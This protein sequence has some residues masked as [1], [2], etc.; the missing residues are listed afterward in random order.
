MRT[1]AAFALATL[2]AG[3]ADPAPRYLPLAQSIHAADP[4]GCAEALV[5]NSDLSAGRL[6]RTAGDIAA[7]KEEEAFHRCY[8]QTKDLLAP[9]TEVARMREIGISRLGADIAVQ[10]RAYRNC[11]TAAG[12]PP[13]P[14]RQPS[15]LA[16]DARLSA[17]EEAARAQRRG[18]DTAIINGHLC[19]SYRD[20]NGMLIANCSR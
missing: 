18:G 5:P 13:P 7:A 1:L 15:P 12:Y 4:L 6:C 20:A 19:Y 11:M 16:V 3:C 8:E 9:P 10:G 14:P 17:A 2:I